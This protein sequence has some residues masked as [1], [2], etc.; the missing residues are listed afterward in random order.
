MQRSIIAAYDTA[1]ECEAARQGV[2]KNGLTSLEERT[3]DPNG[4]AGAE[5]NAAKRAQCIAS[6]DPRL[7]GN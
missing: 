6:D 2:L 1:S 3:D 7:K 4:K 5:V